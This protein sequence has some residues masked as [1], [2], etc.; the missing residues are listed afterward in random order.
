MRLGSLVPLHYLTD[1]LGLSYLLANNGL[2]VA[3]IVARSPP[4]NGIG[5][6]RDMALT[7]MLN[8]QDMRNVLKG[9]FNET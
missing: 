3:C 1:I 9:S 6:T 8:L 4:E 7:S 2:L 5:S